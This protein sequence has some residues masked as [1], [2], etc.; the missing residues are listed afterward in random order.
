MKIGFVSF[1]LAGT[2]GVSLE[3]GKWAEVLHQMGH[4]IYY[5]AGELDPPD[6]QRSLIKVPLDGTQ[7]AERAHFIHPAI[8]WITARAFNTRYVHRDLRTR[9]EN[10]AAHLK[11]ELESFIS[12]YQIDLLIA[13][14]VFAIPLNLP[15]AMA[16]RRIAAETEIPT[17]A[18]N[19]D[20]YWERERFSVTCVDDILYS[21]FPPKLPNVRQVVI[22]TRSQ[23]ALAER[24][25]DSVFIPNV[26]DFGSPLPGIDSYNADLKAEI[27]VLDDELFFLQPTRV[28]QRKGIELSI[29]L[30]RRLS[31]LPIKLVITHHAEFDTLAYLEH[32]YAVAARSHVS[33]HYLPIRFE[34]QRQAGT[35]V[36]KVYSLW[37]AYIHA[38]FVTYPSLYEGFGNALLET[39][40]FRKPMLVNRYPIYRDDIEP[41]G[42]DVISIDEAITDEAVAAV[43]ALLADPA[44]VK[45]M[46]DHNFNVASRYFSYDVLES[47]LKDLLATF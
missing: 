19:H 2:D 29:E 17:I 13:Q 12:R 1:R 30:V 47:K 24:G 43:R 20:F 34:P 23:A 22:N 46:T 10:T 21:T 32:L 3:T 35:G 8:L 26:F 5:F 45:Q 27:G 36:E 11:R 6:A 28:V 44:R 38:D 14:N 31:D 9:M 40:Y 18:H 42:L 15:L 25:F 4:K 41:V 33:L 7:L 39:L 37:D 16:L